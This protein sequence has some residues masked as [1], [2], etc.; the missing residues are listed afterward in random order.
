MTKYSFLT[1]LALPLL[2]MG[3]G[4]TPERSPISTA[5]TGT[6]S[7][8]P[9]ITT[10]NTVIANDADESEETVSI[11]AG[12]QVIKTNSGT[13]TIATK[14]YTD[15][16]AVYAKNGTRLQF[17]KCSGIPGSVTVKRYTK[18]MI[19]SRDGKTHRFGIGTQTFTLGA[20]DYAIISL[21]KTGSYNI[22][23]DGGGAASVSV[24]N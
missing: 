13:S 7:A 8:T 10:P 6:V 20:Y 15:A 9:S 16:L 5:P 4:C 11:Y 23:C 24:Q 2:L 3:A 22:T 17:D 18:F 21:A 12:L 1:V 14:S 19:D